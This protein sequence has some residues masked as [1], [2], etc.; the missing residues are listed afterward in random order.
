MI[1]MDDAVSDAVDAMTVIQV[2]SLM[3]NGP[4]FRSRQKPVEGII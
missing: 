4:G 3:L 1:P 2:C